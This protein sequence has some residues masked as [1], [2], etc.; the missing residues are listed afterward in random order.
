[1]ERRSRRDFLSHGAVIGTAVAT[2]SK[3]LSAEPK[4]K[5]HEWTMVTSW[6]KD[7]PGLYRNVMFMK[8]SIEKATGGQIRITVKNA[9]DLPNVGPLQVFDVVSKGEIAQCGHTTS[10]YYKDKHPAVQFY[11]TVPFGLNSTEAIAWL[12]YGDGQKLWD[13]L[14]G[15]FGLKSFACG[16][17]Q[18]QMGGWF[19]KRIDSVEDLKGLKMR[20]PGLGGEILEELG[21]KTVNLPGNKI[22]DALKAGEIEATEW[23]GPYNDLYTK[24]YEVTKHYYWPGWHEPSSATEFMMNKKA[25][26]A[27][28]PE[29]Q[30]VVEHCC[31]SGYFDMISDYA[32]NN[33]K[34]L[35]TL[36]NQHKVK[37]ERFPDRVL[38]A[39]GKIAKEKLE[40]LAKFDDIT[41][42]I[43]RSFSDFRRDAVWWN[44]IGEEG[45]SLARSLTFTENERT[46]H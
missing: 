39:V 16:T 34:A 7:F 41:G 10:Y 28:S 30:A 3:G 17:T 8:N 37:L 18:V 19:N 24:F 9:G 6:P 1:M 29:L 45:Y 25:W 13:E 4:G 27:L 21:V 20:I 42:R 32:L 14:Y 23:V 40:K 35:V 15:K 33:G 2:A 31:N 26:E 44:K 11:T 43:Y 38:A 5:V 12:R 36:V 46:S 22:Y